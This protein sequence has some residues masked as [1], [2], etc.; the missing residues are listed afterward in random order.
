[1]STLLQSAPLKKKETEIEK[2][3]RIA[4]EQAFLGGGKTVALCL[5]VALSPYFADKKNK[6]FPFFSCR[7]IATGQTA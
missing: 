2:T 6:K 5:L 7:S 3:V 1:M 4:R